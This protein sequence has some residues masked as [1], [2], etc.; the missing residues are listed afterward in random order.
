MNFSRKHIN[1]EN[2]NP[3][4]LAS[5]NENFGNNFQSK[6]PLR[7]PLVK[8]E[9]T[10]S[11]LN[12]AKINVNPTKYP[13]IERDRTNPQNVLEF[14][15]NI[16]EF[17]QQKECF[18][19]TSPFYMDNQSDISDKMRSI[20]IDWLVDVNL[21][22]KLQPQTLFICVNLIDRFLAKERVNR[23][24]VQLVGISVLMIVAK[25]EEIYPPLL[26]DYIG[27]CDNAYD[28]NQILEM[29]SRILIAVNFNL[30]QTSSFSFLQLI[31]INVKLDAKAFVFARYILENALFDL[32]LLKYT[33]YILAVGAVFLAN[34]IFK[35]D[36]WKKEFDSKVGLSEQIAK[37]CAKDLFAMMQIQEKSQLI[38]LK[39][40][41]LSADLFEVSKYRIERVS[42]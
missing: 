39:R 15:K 32:S 13:I 33:N 14:Y 8:S 30:T 28:K 19:Q 16:R 11:L 29:E 7:K 5:N 4:A 9:S 25:F 36:D 42:C 22:F 26:K 10:S 23:S 41:F 12:M 21:K 6:L 18:Y 35:K 27:V 24:E 34:K 17:L 2:I 38:A 3:S 20:L 40:K 31:Q 37:I 1:K